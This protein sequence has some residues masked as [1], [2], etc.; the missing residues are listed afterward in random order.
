MIKWSSTHFVGPLKV[1]QLPM[2]PLNP[3]RANSCICINK[4][5]QEHISG[6]YRTQNYLIVFLINLLFS[7][8][9]ILTFLGP[10]LFPV[11]RCLC[12]WCCFTLLTV[13]LWISTVKPMP[14]IKSSEQTSKRII[15]IFRKIVLY[16]SDIK[17]NDCWILLLV[18]RFTN[19]VHWVHQSSWW[20]SMCEKEENRLMFSQSL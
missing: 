1:V 4:T 5:T 11:A 8:Y 12:L 14:I 18:T 10:H 15:N 16:K 17:L 13:D 19:A 7:L 2:M 9:I 3:L 6:P 20:L